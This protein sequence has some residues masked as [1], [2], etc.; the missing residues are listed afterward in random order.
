MVKFPMSIAIAHLGPAGTYAEEAAL[1]YAN[2]LLQTQQ[3][4][5]HLRPY[6]SIAL[7]LHATAAGET[8]LA[9]VPVENS[10]EGIVTVTLD[11]LWQLDGLQ[12]QEALILPISHALVTQGTDLTKIQTV[13]S[14]PQALA[15]CQN[16]LGKN[17]PQAQL[18]PTPSTTDALRYPQQD[19]GVAAIASHRAA[20]L[21]D[22]P[23]LVSSIQDYADN[24][25]RFWVIGGGQADSFP[26]SDSDYT[27][28][29][30]SLSANA[31]GALL[32]ALQI[33]AE[34]Q[35]NLSRIESRPSKRALGD[36]VFFVDLEVNQRA[37][38]V[39]SALAELATCTDVLKILGNYKAIEIQSPWATRC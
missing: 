28:L 30:F 26:A 36:Y 6:A 17:L 22:L 29:A 9:V 12:V 34:R 33:F 15:Q 32:L 3:Q 13:Y 31:P 23:I 14:H 20:E 35:I 8:H 7:T 1:S 16:W 18:I 5:T 24:C 37:E 4:E 39:K 21:Y 11:T 25:T 19:L 27:S 38:S 10:I 2:W